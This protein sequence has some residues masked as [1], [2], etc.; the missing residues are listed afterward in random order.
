MTTQFRDAKRSEVDR[1]NE[2][3]VEML[4]SIY[5][6]EEVQGYENGYLERFFEDNED[7]ILVAEEEEIVAFLSIQV[8]RQEGY[9]YLDDLSVSEKY[10]DRGIGT[11]LISM[12]EAYA[13]EIRIPAIV[14][15]VEKSNVRAHA[16]YTKLGYLDHE[17]QGTR[18]LMVKEWGMN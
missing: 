2:L 14:F 9:I 8:Y 3:F 5:H 15:H 10:R 13:K 6:T 11:K 4:R 7:R 12:A 16:L 17:D 18:I 1:V